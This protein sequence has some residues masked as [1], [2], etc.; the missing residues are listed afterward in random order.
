VVTRR[1]R[2]T[3][4]VH[5]ENFILRESV[6]SCWNPIL[7][8]RIRRD[9]HAQKTVRGRLLCSSILLFHSG[10][11]MGGFNC[12]NA[13]GARHGRVNSILLCFN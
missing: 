5:I 12:L 11:V 8:K 3:S 4:P 9:C 1:G 7:S 10:L 13:E 2:N 6:S